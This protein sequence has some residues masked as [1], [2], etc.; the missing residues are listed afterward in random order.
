MPSPDDNEQLMRPCG[1]HAALVLEV[2]RE[3]QPGSRPC[4]LDVPFA[5]VGRDE[6]SHLCLSDSQVSRR[7]AYLQ[8]IAEGLL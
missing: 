6:R 4:T 1:A 7:H 2:G 8:V 3:G 5:V